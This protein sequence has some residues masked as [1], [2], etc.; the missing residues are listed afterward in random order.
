MSYHI[1]Y[2]SYCLYPSKQNNV[3]VIACI[4]ISKIMSNELDVCI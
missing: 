1:S 2:E 4:L 3:K